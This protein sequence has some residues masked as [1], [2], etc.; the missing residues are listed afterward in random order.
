MPIHDKE[1]NKTFKCNL[2]HDVINP[3]KCAKQLN[4][5]YYLIIHGCMNTRKVRAGFQNFRIILDSGY[6]SK[7]LMDSQV[8][9]LHPKKR[10]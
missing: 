2:L 8:E 6:S 4:S 7:R 5:Y 1:V 3:N 9:K 10:M